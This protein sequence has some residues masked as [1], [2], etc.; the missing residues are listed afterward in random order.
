MSIDQK[1]NEHVNNKDL[2]KVQSLFKKSLGKKWDI[3]ILTHNKNYPPCLLLKKII[4][5]RILISP[6]G[7]QSVLLLFQPS[8]SLFVEIFPYHFFKPSIYGRIQMNMN[9]LLKI[10]NNNN[11][12]G[13]SRSYLA[14]ESSLKTNFRKSNSNI[15]SILSSLPLIVLHHLYQKLLNSATT[16]GSSYHQQLHSYY[17][18]SHNTKI[19]HNSVYYKYYYYY[20]SSLCRHIL[21]TQ[22]VYINNNFIRKISK[23]INKY[24]I[25]PTVPIEPH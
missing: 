1:K 17:V 6:H 7:F 24:Y 18:N 10:Y 2:L 9:Q 14:F 21:R 13:G 16:C 25:L 19:D 12:S 8:H 20:Y 23:F 4:N 22:D 11:S 3:D 5:S 15:K